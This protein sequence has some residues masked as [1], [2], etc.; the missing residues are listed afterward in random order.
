[1]ADQPIQAEPFLDAEDADTV[2]GRGIP[3]DPTSMDDAAGAPATRDPKR[4]SDGAPAD[5]AAT[6]NIAPR[7]PMVP[8]GQPAVGDDRPRS[9]EF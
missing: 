3:A 5:T 7:E 8:G 2:T 6:G 4:A 1:M 9:T